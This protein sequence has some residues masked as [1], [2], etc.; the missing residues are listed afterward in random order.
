MQDNRQGGILKIDDK[1]PFLGLQKDVSTYSDYPSELNYCHR[2]KHLSL[3]SFSHQ[4]DFCLTQG[5]I[6]CPLMQE[7]KLKGFPKFLVKPQPGQGR[8]RNIL[9]AFILF[10]LMLCVALF[11]FGWSRGISAAINSIISDKILNGSSPTDQSPSFKTRTPTATRTLTISPTFIP[12]RTFTPTNKPSST[13]T[14]T[15]IEYFDLTATYESALL[16]GSPTATP[17]CNYSLI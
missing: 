7:K 10:V 12:T 16:L 4:R 2:R 15:P 11:A 8:R 5:Y 13:A 9:I 14:Q 1:C 6:N 17:G 3:P